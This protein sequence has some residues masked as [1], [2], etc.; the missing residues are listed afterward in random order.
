MHIGGNGDVCKRM[1]FTVV[2]DSDRLD[3][4]SFFERVDW[5]W[6][7]KWRNRV[8]VE[9]RTS[10][11][12]GSGGVRLDTTHQWTERLV[13]TFVHF[14]RA[15][16]RGEKIT[17]TAEVCW[18]AMCLPFVRGR[19]PDVFLVSFTDVTSLV[20]HVVVLPK[21]WQVNYEELGLTEGEDSYAI[22]TS[23]NRDGRVEAAL[24]ARDVPGHRKIG[25][26]LD[27]RPVA[28]G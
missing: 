18:P 14:D 25:L 19:G 11:N 23:L 20:E 9:V 6:P 26:K 4:V 8:S 1:V 16:R 22:A 27:R 3:F 17:L 21:G 24:T 5:D 15:M 12:G 13:K 2:A 7:L 10:T 28:A